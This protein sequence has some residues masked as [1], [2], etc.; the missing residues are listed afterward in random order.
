M[1][2]GMTE[3]LGRI[4]WITGGVLGGTLLMLVVT[5]SCAGPAL[6]PG[7]YAKPDPTVMTPSQRKIN[8]KLLRLDHQVRTE[9]DSITAV[10]AGMGFVTTGDRVLLDIV[11]DRQ[12]VDIAA[13][14]SPVV[15]NPILA[16]AAVIDNPSVRTW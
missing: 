8:A 16:A 6:A 7:A 1:K 11:I 15:T 13:K 2:W 9:G 10:A 14:L 3:C 5:T 12:A 4:R